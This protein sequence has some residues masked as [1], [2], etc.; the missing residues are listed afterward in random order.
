MP[1]GQWGKT[2]VKLTYQPGGGRQPFKVRAIRNGE[3]TGDPATREDLTT[4]LKV[5][6]SWTAKLRAESRS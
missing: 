6:D 2:S 4:A 5:F 3:P 1:R